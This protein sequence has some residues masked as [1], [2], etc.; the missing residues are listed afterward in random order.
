M[1]ISL[2]CGHPAP[3]WQIGEGGWVVGPGRKECWEGEREMK[4]PEVSSSQSVSQSSCRV[5]VI[6]LSR[7][8]CS[9]RGSA[10]CFSSVFIFCAKLAFRPRRLSLSCSPAILQTRSPHHL[11]THNITA[12]H[13]HHPS[14]HLGYVLV[15]QIKRI[16]ILCCICGPT[17]LEDLECNIQMFL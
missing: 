3:A 1:R 5:G 4:F 16:S 13:S 10:D 14:H 12:G 2:L 17:L 8:E 15:L 11:T 9:S 6:E 7:F